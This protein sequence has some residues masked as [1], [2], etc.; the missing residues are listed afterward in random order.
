M[1]SVAFDRNHFE[2]MFVGSVCSCLAE[3]YFDS[4]KA[5]LRPYFALKSL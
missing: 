4:S 1:L 3:K 2:L 5:R